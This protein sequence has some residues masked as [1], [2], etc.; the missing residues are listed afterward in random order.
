MLIRLLCSA[1]ALAT[2]AAVAEPTPCTPPRAGVWVEMAVEDGPRSSDVADVK[3]GF[4]G[5]SKWWLW[6]SYEPLT[7][8]RVFDARCNV[9]RRTTLA[10]GT[11]H[12]RQLD[13]RH[14]VLFGDTALAVYAPT[15][16]ESPDGRREAGP[17]AVFV[18]GRP[19]HRL[20]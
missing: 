8:S 7:E 1:V 5:P 12:P 3:T 20:G 13:R 4:L 17:L 10:K 9:W 2:T 11:R 15:W 14:G 18:L 16:E 19:P 6:N